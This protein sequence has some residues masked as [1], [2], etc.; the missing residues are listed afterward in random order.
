MV[1]EYEAGALI[2]FQ[3]AA[4][5]TFVYVP[6]WSLISVSKN[7]QNAASAHAFATRIPD[8]DYHYYYYYGTRF[9]IVPSSKV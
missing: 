2:A 1:Y 5:G 8:D 3:L 4:N 6:N 7:V 9:G